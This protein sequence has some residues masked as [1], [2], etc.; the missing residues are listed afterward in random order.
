MEESELQ[1]LFDKMCRNGWVS[2]CKTI[3]SVTKNEMGLCFGVPCSPDPKENWIFYDPKLIKYLD[4]YTIIWMILHEEGHRR[5]RC[6]GID[7]E[8]NNVTNIDKWSHYDHEYN[9]D[10]YAAR[11]LNKTCDLEQVFRSNEEK[12]KECCKNNPLC[13]ILGKIQR[14]HLLSYYIMNEWKFSKRTHPTTGERIEHMKE[15]CKRLNLD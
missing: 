3:K 11:I 9:A 13:S 6:G 14:L 1:P 12:Y 5:L 2:Y 7:C 8:N 15:L 10:G 4:E